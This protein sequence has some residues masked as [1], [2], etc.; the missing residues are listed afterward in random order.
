[1]RSENTGAEFQD[2]DVVHAYRQRTDYPAALYHR[3][4]QLAPGRTKL[5]DLGCGPGQFARR[6]APRF[7]QVLAVDPSSAMLRLARSLDGGARENIEWIEATAEAAALDGPVDLIVAGASIHWMDAGRVFP[8]LAQ[9]LSPQGVVAIVSGDGPAEAP[10]L[11]IWNAMIIEWIGRVGD[12]WNGPSHRA[13]VAAHEPWFEEK[14][15]ETFSA[16]ATQ[17]VEDLIEAEH[18]RATWSRSKM[19]E[20]AARFDADLRAVLAPHATDDMVAFGVRSTL[21]WGRPRATS[22]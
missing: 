13:R 18:S 5:I 17:S 10:W 19:G 14:G 8:K 9:V 1:V 11:G 15:R 6:L 22:R 12:V 2:E 3:L 20:R 4:L 21:T 7:F 16:P